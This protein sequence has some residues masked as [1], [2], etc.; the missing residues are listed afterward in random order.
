LS[1][2]LRTMA[3]DK[4]SFSF[5]AA[6]KLQAA[7]QQ[8][9][10]NETSVFDNGD[11][12]GEGS[13]KESG[14]EG[15]ERKRSAASMVIPLIEN[16]FRRERKPK[17]DTSLNDVIDR[18]EHSLAAQS[19]LERVAAGDATADNKGSDLVIPLHATNANES[20]T[21]KQD[22]EGRPSE[23]S[24]ED[25]EKVPVEGFGLALLRGMGWNP[26]DEDRDAQDKAKSGSKKPKIEG[27][28]ARPVRLGL[29]ALPPVPGTTDAKSQHKSKVMKTEKE[30]DKQKDV[31]SG[32]WTVGCYVDVRE[33]KYAGY[34]G[35]CE[36][37]SSDRNELSL[38]FFLLDATISHI[39]R[40]ICRLVSSQQ[41][42]QSK[43]VRLTVA[44]QE[45]QARL[46][47]LQWNREDVWLWL[48][49]KVVVISKLLGQGKLMDSSAVIEDYDAK[50]KCVLRVLSG[51]CVN[52]IFEGV[53][54]SLLEVALPAVGDRCMIID[55]SKRGKGGI[56]VHC[57]ANEVILRM[58]TGDD[59]A[60]KIRFH[61]MKVAPLLTM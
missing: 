48:G 16:T 35:R 18:D 30:K 7:K 60:Q 46:D 39:S 25:Y 28:V 8:D 37:M 53:D 41:A 42:T 21:Y 15:R 5:T 54:Q 49:I 2:P 13:G 33:G 17:T 11:S 40:S 19:L 1:P 31:W 58:E 26:A 45:R 56:A 59:D 10:R 32:G 9:G 34:Y 27:N 38:Y 52:R 4:V 24:L 43:Q 44:E 3:T 14:D 50:G 47:K 29:G 20:D 55:G 12:S 22:L 23:C 51:P 61:P 36:S 57:S 6:A